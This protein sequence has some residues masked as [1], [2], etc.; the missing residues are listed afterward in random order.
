MTSPAEPAETPSFRVVVFAAPDD[1]SDLGEVLSGVLGLHP[2]DALVQARYAPGLLPDTLPEKTARHLVDEIGK[3]GIHAA[4][5]PMAQV[6]CLDDVEMVHHLRLSDEGLQII[7]LHGMTEQLV[8]WPSVELISVGQ[9][10]QE[11]TRHFASSDMNTVR[12]ARRT[13][14][15][16]VETPLSPGPEAWIVC[17]DPERYFR[18]DHKRM[19]YEYLGVRKSDSAT[20]N[21]RLFLEDFVSQADKV[22]R[23]PAT[24][25]F[26][27][28][29]SSVADYSFDSAEELQRMTQFHLLLHR[30]ANAGE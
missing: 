29:G 14:P 21:F 3:I 2:T 1:P 26:L 15:S 4:A 18:V 10:P 7:D 11:T 17:A 12:S 28:H 24:R 23:T 16:T 19:N 30:L 25:S 20:T 27:K 8:P 6:P 9:V 5:V 22:Y 13:G